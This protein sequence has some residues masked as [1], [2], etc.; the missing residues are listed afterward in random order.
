MT[1]DKKKIIKFFNDVVAKQW[2]RPLKFVPEN[3][4]K[5][6]ASVGKVRNYTGNEGYKLLIIP[7]I[8]NK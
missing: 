6:N 4:F 1:S 2:P 8:G 7:I 3:S 5:Q